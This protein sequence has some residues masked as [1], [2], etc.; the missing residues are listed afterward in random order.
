MD[1]NMVLSYNYAGQKKPAVT[2]KCTS[3]AGHFHGRAE[4]LKRFM[5][6]RLMQLDQ[7]FHKSQ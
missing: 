3:V 1:H 7:G 4:A 2:N 6:H 5:R